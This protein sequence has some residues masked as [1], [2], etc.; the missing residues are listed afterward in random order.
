MADIFDSIPLGDNLIVGIFSEIHKAHNRPRRDKNDDTSFL[1]IVLIAALFLV[2]ATEPFKVIMRRNIGKD[3][4]SLP[5]III[6]SILYLAWAGIIWLFLYYNNYDGNEVTEYPIYFQYLL[7]QYILISGMVCYAIFAIFILF[8]GFNEYNREEETILNVAETN[9]VFRGQSILMGNLLDEG[10]DQFKIWRI[11]EPKA[12][13]KFA[14][15]L[16]IIHPI[17]GLPIFLTSISFW[18]NEWFHVKFKWE[19]LKNSYKK[20]NEQMQT[21]AF[22]YNRNSQSSNSGDFMEA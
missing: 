5:G 21:A 10:L 11:A 16:F 12:C 22:L 3:A 7:N 15:I 14:L 6:S 2:V 18:I 13:F 4:L 19:R 20:L 17:I 8:R 1:I 9:I